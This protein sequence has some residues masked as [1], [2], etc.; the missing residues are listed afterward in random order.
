M[1]GSSWT[2][3]GQIAG[4]GTSNISVSDH[5]WR[6][7]EFDI[8]PFI[9]TNTGVRIVSHLVHDDYWDSIYIDNVTITFDDAC[10][11]MPTNTYLETLRV[12]PVW[13]MGLNGSGITVAVVDSSIAQDDDFSAIAGEPGSDRLIM[14]LG[15]NTSAYTVEDVYGHGTH[16][17]G[18]IAGNGTKSDG[19]YKGVAPGVNLI[20]L[21]ISDDYGKAYESDTVA[22]LQWIF[23]NKDAYNIRVVN[24][25]IQSTVEQSYHDSA[26]D[27]AVEILWFN[28]VVVVA[29]TGNKGPDD[30]FNPVLAAPANDPFI[31]TVGASD[32]NGDGR[33]VGND[34]LARFTAYDETIDFFV[35][36]DIIAPG[37]KISSVFW[38]AAPGGATIT[39]IALWMAV[40]SG[41]AVLPCQR[42]WLLEP[43]RFSFN[44]NPI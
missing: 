6:Y 13:D 39:P 19:F 22:A 26:L 3:V 41:S 10:S 29:A 35:K 32:E 23:E 5:G 4:N 9:S 43:L 33:P 12:P 7:A 14:R 28:G 11:A 40:I 31:I 38:Q 17:A 15:F 36:P 25:S 2:E 37:V 34:Q 8:T 24:L 20:A 27:A 18:I 1:A 16:V 44:P 21:K 30:D 42:L